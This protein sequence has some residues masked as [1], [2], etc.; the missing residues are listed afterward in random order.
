MTEPQSLFV[1]LEPP[2]GG[3]QRLH[4]TIE[5]QRLRTNPFDGTW[6][7]GA[8]AISM[9][10]AAWLL[11]GAIARYQQV[12]QLTEAMLQVMPATDNRLHVVNG[13]ALEWPTNR[14]DVRLFFV[15]SAPSREH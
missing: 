5:R 12:G 6:V 1:P 9:L 11:P 8:L 7:A 14:S 15:Q 2:A 13:N 3:M 4:R 10:V